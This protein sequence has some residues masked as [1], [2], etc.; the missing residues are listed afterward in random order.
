LGSGWA[1][2]EH[3]LEDGVV[4]AE[5]K[6]G[7]GRALFFGPEILKRAQPHGTFPLLFN[8]LLTAGRQ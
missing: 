2:G 3:Y 4:A 8:A 5:A 7:K 6:V 1:W